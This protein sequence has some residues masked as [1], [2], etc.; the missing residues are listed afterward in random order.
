MRSKRWAAAGAGLVISAAFL[1]IAF[2]GLHPEAVLRHIR[3][4]NLAWLVAGAGVY[5]LAVAAISLRW[6][7]L[8]RAARALPLRALMPLVSIGYMGNNVYP[9]RS[10]EVLRVVLLQHNHQ[11][12]LARGMTTVVVE[13]VFDGLV[14]LSFILVSLLF[15]EISSPEIRSVAGFAAPI[16]LGAVVVFFALAARP[17]ALRWLRARVDQFL[18]GRLRKPVSHL[19]EGVIG[20]LEGLRTPADLAGAVV[21]SVVSW[22]IEASVYWLVSFGFG[23]NVSY[24]LMLLV[25]G[26]VNLAGLIPASPG[27]LGV[28]EFFVA[29]V[30]VGAGIPQA[31]AN[32]YALVVHLVIWLPVTLAGFYFLVRQGLGWSAITHARDLEGQPTVESSRSSG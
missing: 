21:F 1:W 23:L 19:V 7:F 15:V 5:F 29:L 13:R 2:R 28:F 27:Q 3:Q 22:G 16:F 25:V 32:A 17:N 8:L 11:V 6:G 20:G 18:P 31:Q 4:A 14:M 10:G 24:P 12:P 26:V 9:F 30:L